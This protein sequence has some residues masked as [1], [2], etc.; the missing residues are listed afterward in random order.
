MDSLIN[1]LNYEDIMDKFLQWF[2]TGEYTAHGKI[3][4]ISIGTRKALI[5]FKNGTPPLECGG[6]S[7]HDNGNGSLMRILPVLFYIQSIY[8]NEFCKIEEAY[9]IIHNISSLTHGYKRSQMA[10]GIYIS[11][12]SDIYG[13]RD[14]TKKAQILI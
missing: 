4:D 3:F 9:E 13:S 1:G 6:K 2:N 14:A 8:G 10:C 11:I 5:R 12:A 7:E